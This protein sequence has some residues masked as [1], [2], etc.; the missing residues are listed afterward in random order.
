MVTVPEA[1]KIAQNRFPGLRVGQLLHVVLADTLS[2]N[3]E[4][5]RLFYIT[6]EM[7]ATEIMKYVYKFDEK[8]AKPQAG[9]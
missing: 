7:L 6:D 3:L 9:A 1:I 5:G 4:G 2:G 8:D